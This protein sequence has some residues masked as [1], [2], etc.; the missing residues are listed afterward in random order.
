[1]APSDVDR[2]DVF[3]ALLDA[4]LA[5]YADARVVSVV[6]PVVHERLFPE[7][8]LSAFGFV[9]AT[10]PGLSRF[11]GRDN[12]VFVNPLGGE[13]DDALTVGG[14]DLREPENWAIEVR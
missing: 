7:E 6:G 14:V 12:T 13:P 4:L 2:Q 5:D 8:T 10:R 11:A 9:S 1:V 3:G